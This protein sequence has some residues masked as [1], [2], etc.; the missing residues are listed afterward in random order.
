MCGMFQEHKEHFNTSGFSNIIQQPITVF[1]VVTAAAPLLVTCQ[2]NLP[3][4]QAC[5]QYESLNENHVGFEGEG[6]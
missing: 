6:V 5:S 4:V 3:V 2:C 1:L